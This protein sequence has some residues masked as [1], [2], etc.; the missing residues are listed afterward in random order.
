MAAAIFNAAGSVLVPEFGVSSGD[1]RDPETIAL[2]DGGFL[3][4][5]Q[6]TLGSAIYL[7]RYSAVGTVVGTTVTVNTITSG[8]Q[9]HPDFALTDDGRVIVAW[10][11]NSMSS[12]DT[13]QEAVRSQILSLTTDNII[14]SS[15]GE[16]INGNGNDNTIHGY[17][18][19][20]EIHAGNGHDVINAGAGMDDVYAGEGN[21]IIIDTE[22]GGAN[23]ADIYRGEGGIDTLVAEAIFW[24]S[25]TAFNLTTGWQTVSGGTQR[26]Q[27]ISIENLRISGDASLVGD[28]QDNELIATDTMGI[29]INTINGMAGDDT[30]EG[31]GGGGSS[32]VEPTMRWE[33]H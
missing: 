9:S 23:N 21:D 19:D 8:T 18:G 12:G 33:T 7:Q 2:D 6:D 1:A 22:L 30:I 10:T 17:E 32:M 4:T 25:I 31:G 16:T 11:D 3:V 26:D 28:S 20:D 14:G 13:S 5:W 15:I 24:S 29:G 27:L